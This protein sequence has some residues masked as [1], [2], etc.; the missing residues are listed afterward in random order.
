LITGTAIA[1]LTKWLKQKI[2]HV[3][4]DQFLVTVVGSCLFSL[5]AQPKIAE[6][7]GLSPTDV[8][9]FMKRRRTEL[10]ALLTRT[11]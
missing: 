2:A 10:P 8:G 4:A 7:L 6:A 3:S 9:Q 11:L 1:S 5:V